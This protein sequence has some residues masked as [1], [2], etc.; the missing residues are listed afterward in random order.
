MFIDEIGA[1]YRSVA[2]SAEPVTLDEAKAQLRVTED[3]EDTYIESLIL[4]ATAYAEEKT[5]LALMTQTWVAT[6][7]N[8][9]LPDGGIVE[10]PRPP[11]QSLVSISY[12]DEN[13][14]TQTLPV[15][16]YTVDTES[17]PGRLIFENMPTIS[18]SPNALT[19]TWKAG[20]SD[21]ASIPTNIKQGILLMVA[22]WFEFRTP[23]LA[24]TITTKVPQSADTLLNLSRMRWL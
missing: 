9:T 20:Y 15:A 22:H 16:N 19:I 2:A 7:D 17:V 5:N 11:F 18:D 6:I 10:L 14:A 13:D 24:G 21:A 23:V 12:L 1:F 4:A 8:G 3:A